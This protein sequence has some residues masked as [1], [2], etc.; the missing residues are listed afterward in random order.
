[1][2]TGRAI[3]HPAL[4]WSGRSMVGKWSVSGYVSPPRPLRRGLGGC[5]PTALPTVPA[6][7]AHLPT[8][9]VHEAATI[10]RALRLRSTLNAEGSAMSAQ[11]A[12]AAH[13][14]LDPGRRNVRP[15]QGAQAAG[16]QHMAR[17]TR[18]PLTR[19]RPGAGRGH[20]FSWAPPGRAWCTPKGFLVDFLCTTR[21]G[22]CLIQECTAA[23]RVRG[24]SLARARVLRRF[25]G[26][27]RQGTTA[28]LR[29]E[30]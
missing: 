24:L 21:S 8:V 12:Q 3:V 9:G 30:K 4:C 5:L 10:S 2:S 28:P 27:L 7:R 29:S 16:G 6:R 20:R 19:E 22:H 17:W 15:P 13:H 14:A 1:M 25:S 26:I 11:A 23:E 18:P